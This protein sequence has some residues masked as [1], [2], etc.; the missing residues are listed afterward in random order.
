MTRHVRVI[1]I[2]IE[3]RKSG[4]LDGMGILGIAV[5]IVQLIARVFRFKS[6]RPKFSLLSDARDESAA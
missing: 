6:E 5:S 2:F 4:G 3:S 1:H